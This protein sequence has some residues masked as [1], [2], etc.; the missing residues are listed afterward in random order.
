MCVCVPVCLCMRVHM[1]NV[2]QRL[3]VCVCVCVHVCRVAAHERLRRRLFRARVLL[4][5]KI[6]RLI[7]GAGSRARTIRRCESARDHT[8]A[9]YTYMYIYI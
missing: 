2:Y 1:Y 7:Y 3:C 5:E 6:F 9:S 4:R 8:G